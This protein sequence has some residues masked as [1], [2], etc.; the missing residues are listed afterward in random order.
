[1]TQQQTMTKTLHPLDI[2]AQLDDFRHMK[3][4]WLEGEGIAPS[5]S[6]LDWLA[7]RF[8]KHYQP[9]LPL[10]YIYPT[11]E[12]N[13]EAEWEIGTQSVIF[14]IDIENHTGHWLQCDDAT[15]EESERN[16]KLDDDEDWA[17]AVSAIRRMAETAK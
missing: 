12:G 9:D 5:H 3:D 17:W 11:P 1:M 13:V 7:D 2:P 16:L 10:P 8:T 4:G 6:G 14:E 15:D